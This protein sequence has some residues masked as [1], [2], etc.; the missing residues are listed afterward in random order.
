MANPLDI[1][2]S[3]LGKTEGRD[4]AAIMDYLTT[5]GVNLDPATLAWCAA[6]VNSTLEQAGI[7]GTGSNMARSFLKWGEQVEGTPQP[8]DIGVWPRGDPS[9]PYGHVGF[10]E[11]V[12]P[13]TGTVT[14]LAG[15]QGNAV[16]AK[17]Y[18]MA[19]ALGFRRAGVGGPVEAAGGGAVDPQS[20]TP[21]PPLPPPYEVADRPIGNPMAEGPRNALASMFAKGKADDKPSMAELFGK[22]VAGMGTAYGNAPRSSPR[23][24]GVPA[25]RID[26]PAPE[27]VIDT[28]QSDQQR[29]M[30]ATAL[31][32]LNSGRLFV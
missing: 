26:A 5:G 6:F 25:A 23:I 10:V 32:R 21:A 29:Q 24:G 18:P 4:R 31:A 2:S 27:P 16:S 19:S 9:G 13:N 12:D 17:A 15:N 22:G 14:L 1:A 28:A 20:S 8:G 3:M 7:K 30:L 11:S